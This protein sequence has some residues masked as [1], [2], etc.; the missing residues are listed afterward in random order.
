[1]RRRSRTRATRSRPIRPCPDWDNTKAGTIFEQMYTKANGNFVGV[2]SANDGLGGAVASVL[3]RNGDRKIPTTGQDAT[4]EGLQ[5]VLL[6]SQCMT[7]YKAIKKEADAAAKLAIALAKGDTAGGRRA[8]DRHGQGHRDQAGRQVGAAR[9]RRRSS[10]RTSRTS[11]PTA[12]PRRTRSAPRRRCSL[13]EDGVS[14]TDR[15]PSRPDPARPRGRRTAGRASTERSASDRPSTQAL[16]SLRGINKSF[17]A[18][19]VLRDVDL[20]VSSGRGH[21]PRRG[22]RRRQE[23]AHQVHRRDPPVRLAAR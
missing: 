4:D 12:S 23:H 8:G 13:H 16:L 1:M 21:R 10:R 5:R 9:R 2:D 22:Q 6:G 15:A 18:V 20:D 19:Q 17:G 3:K 7:V 11:S 14:G